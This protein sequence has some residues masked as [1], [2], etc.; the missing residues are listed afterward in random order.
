MSLQIHTLEQ[1]KRESVHGGS[2]F[3]L[4]KNR[5][6]SSKWVRWDPARKVFYVRG[7]LD[8]FEEEV[9]E[10]QIYNRNWTAVGRALRQ[11]TLY[12]YGWSSGGEMNGAGDAA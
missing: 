3:I 1:L 6:K 11:G 7:E 4:L 12:K 2:F 9:P 8:D 5:M 10:Y